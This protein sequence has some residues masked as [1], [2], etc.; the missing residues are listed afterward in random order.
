[1]PFFFAG[2]IYVALYKEHPSLIGMEEKFD[3]RF[4]VQS[5]YQGSHF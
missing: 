1:M 2:P 4:P 5:F 3:N